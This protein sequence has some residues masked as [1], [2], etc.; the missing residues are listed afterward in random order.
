MKIMMMMM[1]MMTMIMMMIMMM[2]MMMLV[3]GCW[4]MD[5]DDDDDD[6]DDNDDDDDADNND[7]AKTKEDELERFK[8]FYILDPENDPKNEVFEINTS[9]QYFYIAEY[10]RV[11][12]CL[13]VKEKYLKIFWHR[14]V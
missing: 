4:M 10:K 7:D 14:C 11:K 12:I 9:R 1:M 5:D 2:M 6:D 3:D 8:C 13:Y